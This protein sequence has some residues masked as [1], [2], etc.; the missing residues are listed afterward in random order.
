MEVDQEVEGVSEKAVIR[1]VII[2]DPR[3]SDDEWEKMERAVGRLK[4]KFP[5]IAFGKRI[6][7]DDRHNPYFFD[8]YLDGTYL[9]SRGG[10]SPEEAECRI[11]RM[12]TRR[13]TS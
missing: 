3:I 1:S 10:D 11:A 6:E 2:D 7:P 5:R 4:E 8:A 13:F 9:I 12:L